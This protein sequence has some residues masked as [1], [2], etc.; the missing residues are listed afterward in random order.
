M[1]VKM[2]LVTNSNESEY[3]KIQDESHRDRKDLF[4]L[5]LG[6]YSK[7]NVDNS[8]NT[9]NYLVYEKEQVI[10]CFAYSKYQQSL[11]AT[12]SGIFLIKKYRGKGIFEQ[13]AAFLGNVIFIELGYNKIEASCWASNKEVATLYSK[14]MDN[15]GIQK[16][17]YY[18]NRKFVDQLNFGTTYKNS[19]WS[20]GKVKTAKDF[21]NRKL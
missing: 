16:D 20:D 9:E 15:E 1:K 7:D 18:W 13:I 14:L 17:H 19:I 2:V 3:R 4:Q 6:W 21:K 8:W 10:G 11:R 12:I 5:H